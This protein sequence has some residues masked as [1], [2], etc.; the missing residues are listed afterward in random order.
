MIIAIFFLILCFFFLE[1]NKF[2]LSQNQMIN[3]A[4]V[5]HI[6]NLFLSAKSD[7]TQ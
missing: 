4:F 5:A 3:L 7:R 1:E 2:H 6:S